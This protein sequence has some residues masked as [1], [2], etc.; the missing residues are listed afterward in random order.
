MIHHHRAHHYTV[1]CIQDAGYGE[2]FFFAQDDDNEEE[3]Q[4]KMD[5]EVSWLTNICFMKFTITNMLYGNSFN[6]HTFS[7]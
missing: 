1:F 4:V 3:L 2:K 7:V 6:F 5:D